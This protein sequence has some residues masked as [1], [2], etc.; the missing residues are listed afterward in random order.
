MIT[1]NNEIIIIDTNEPRGHCSA[2]NCSKLDVTNWLKDLPKSLTYPDIVEI[3]FKNTRKE[4]F[5]NT[6]ELPLKEGDIVAVEASPGHDIGIVSITG[7]LVLAQMRK[8]GIQPTQ[9]MKKIYRKAKDFDIE[10]WNESAERED[11]VMIKSRKI[12]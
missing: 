2:C 12:A 8:L 4:F 6:N 7:E 10:K 5:R 1:E 3:R 9:D 11:P